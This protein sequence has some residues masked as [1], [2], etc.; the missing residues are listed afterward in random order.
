MKTAENHAMLPA[1]DAILDPKPAYCFATGRLL[2]SSSQIA[3]TPRYLQS[4]HFLQYYVHQIANV[5]VYHFHYRCSLRP[6]EGIKSL[7]SGVTNSSETALRMLGI[8]PRSFGR[9]ASVPRCWAISLSPCVCSFVIWL[10]ATFDSGNQGRIE[11]SLG[12]LEIT[13]LKTKPNIP[14]IKQTNKKKKKGKK[15]NCLLEFIF[16]LSIQ[17]TFTIKG[18]Y[19]R[20]WSQWGWLMLFTLATVWK[21]PRQ[22]KNQ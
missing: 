20:L 14:Q 6:G 15:E 11:V 2:T 17:W 5:P 3:A 8:E 1:L 10:T 21:K 9:A 19:F 13:C 18:K 12:Y 22:Y 4:S 16:H 7:E